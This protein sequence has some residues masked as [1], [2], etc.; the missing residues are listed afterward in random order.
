M[1][2][3]Y[4]TVLLL[5]CPSLSEFLFLPSVWVSILI[6]CLCLSLTNSVTRWPDYFSVLCHLQKWKFPKVE[7][8]AKQL[9]FKHSIICQTIIK[10]TNVCQSS[11]ISSNLV[12]LL[13]NLLS[14]P[15]FLLFCV[16][17]MIWERLL[18]LLLVLPHSR[19]IF[20][21]LFYLFWK[22]LIVSSGAKLVR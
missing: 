13:T 7:K 6:F 15:P 21:D 4:L 9:P 20:A 16:C 22:N 3:K 5:L 2:F 8:F 10:P 18:L 14:I 11:K 17:R 19:A 12:T 1:G